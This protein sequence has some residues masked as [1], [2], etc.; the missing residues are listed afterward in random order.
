MKRA[1]L[2]LAALLML[3][4]VS[5]FSQS[6]PQ[7]MNFQGRL[8]KPD[9]TPVPNVL[10]QGIT[11]N[12]YSAATGGTLLWSQFSKVPVHNG[13]FAAALDFT[14]GF[15]A[16]Q[17]VTAVFGNPLITPYLEIQEGNPMSRAEPRAGQ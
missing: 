15:T 16:G 2:A 7:T 13:A 17:S 4:T 12:I 10:L 9:G 14:A 8:A 1:A 3:L 6:V 5:A 11:F